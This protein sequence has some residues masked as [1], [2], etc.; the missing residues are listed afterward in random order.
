MKH[1]E[2]IAIVEKEDD[3]WNKMVLENTKDIKI[4]L[5]ELLA[6][7]RNEITAIQANFLLGRIREGGTIILNSVQYEII[8]LKN[9]TVDE[10][11]GIWEKY[12]ITL[13][14]EDESAF[15][16]YEFC[17]EHVVLK[18]CATTAKKKNESKRAW[19]WSEEM[20]L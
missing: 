8:Y 12:Y 2:K 5:H 4:E 17:L 14:R 15:F 16:R 3:I 10:L 20:S 18:G 13:Q 9:E 19:T 11:T 7:I 1:I 6:N